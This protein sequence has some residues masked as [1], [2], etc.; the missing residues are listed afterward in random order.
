M[1]SNQFEARLLV[2]YNIEKGTINTGQF[3]EFN[4]VNMNSAMSIHSSGAAGPASSMGKD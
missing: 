3:L 2:H 4:W 1:E